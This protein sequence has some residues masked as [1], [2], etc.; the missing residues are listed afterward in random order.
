MP[1]SVTKTMT[2]YVVFELLKSGRLSPNQRVTISEKAFEDWSRKGSTMYLEPD[3]PATID[4]LLMGLLTV[5]ANDGAVV[6]AETGAGSVADWVKLMNH[7]ARKLEMTG[8]HFGTPNGFPD[9]GHTFTTANDLVKLARAIIRQHPKRF[10][11]YF[12][13]ETFE[14]NEIEQR[15]HDPMVGR[16]KGADGFKTGYTREAG[17]T[18]LGT[19]ERRGQRLVLVLAAVP[20]G[21]MRDRLARE[22]IEWGFETFDR[23]R[24]F[25]KSAEVGSARV[26]GG[27]ARSVTLVTDRTVFANVP[28]DR[29]SQLQAAIQ[30]DGPVRAPIK[31]GE[32]VGTLE[33]NVP[34]M[35]PARV[36][37]LARDGVGEA[38]FFDRFVNGLAGWFS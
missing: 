19:A 31:A 2:A 24:L 25:E 14:W 6:L 3:T 32:R 1:A 22:Y 23:E 11:R 10:A 37:L 4:Q 16:V 36:P 17:F 28:K 33:I 12:G 38:G 35:E 29:A 15:N 13:H 5:S 7:E 34:G 27:D 20:S 30:Y 21:H 26:Q 18:Y 8:S 9:E